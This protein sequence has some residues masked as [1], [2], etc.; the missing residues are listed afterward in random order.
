MLL[1]GPPA[2]AHKQNPVNVDSTA[3]ASLY[4]GISVSREKQLEFLGRLLLV[5]GGVSM[6]GHRDVLN[7]DK[8]PSQV[9][10]ETTLSFGGKNLLLAGD[11]RKLAKSSGSH[12]SNNQQT[13]PKIKYGRLPPFT[14]VLRTRN[15]LFE[16]GH[17]HQKME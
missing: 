14:Q 8:F 6:T 15:D 5:V 16:P 4:S 3:I 9:F 13:K 7:L 12:C 1:W 2:H 10:E 17:A 11:P